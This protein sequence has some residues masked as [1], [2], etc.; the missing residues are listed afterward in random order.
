MDRPP[1]A[2]FSLSEAG[3]FYARRCEE[4]SRNLALD[5]A[6]LRALL[7]LAENIGVTQR[8]LSETQFFEV[9][10][11]SSLGR[12][13]RLCVQIRCVEASVAEPLRM[14]V[15]SVPELTSET[16]AALF[17]TRKI[18][19][20]NPAGSPDNGNNRRG[21]RLPCRPPACGHTR[22]SNQRN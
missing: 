10:E 14:T 1:V 16:A 2:G 21:D 22:P 15:T 5:L 12:E 3:Q 7:V 11:G 4:R 9:L 18:P 20:S 13:V 6:Q 8:R 19:S 17:V